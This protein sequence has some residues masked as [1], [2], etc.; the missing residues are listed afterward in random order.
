[1]EFTSG[2]PAWYEWNGTRWHRNRLGYYQN[3]VGVLMHTCVWESVH[4]RR[5]PDDWIVHHIDHDR[6]NNQPRNL[7]AMSRTDHLREH[8][9]LG[10]PQTP[11]AKR[12]ISLGQRRSWAKRK[13]RPRVCA[14]CG[15][16]YRSTGQRAKFCGHL[17]RDRFYRE[18]YRAKRVE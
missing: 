11:A 4:G 13:P 6:G 9:L 7:L 17:C 3:N 10:A 5:V 15:R 14:Q 1:M 2:P 16:G 8:G 18:G 12:K